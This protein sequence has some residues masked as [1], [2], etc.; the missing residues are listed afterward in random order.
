MSQT[1]KEQ[2]RSVSAV[3]LVPES[4]SDK[5]WVQLKKFKELLDNGIINQGEFDNMKQGAIMLMEHNV[6][7]MTGNA[8]QQAS[9]K[10]VIV[11]AATNRPPGK[12]Y[13]GESKSHEMVIKLVSKLVSKLILI[14]KPEQ[15]GKTYEVLCRM[16][17][18]YKKS[19]T[20][21]IVFCDNSLLQTR[22]T[23]IR[24]AQHNGLGKVCEISSDPS[25]DAKTGAELLDIFYENDAMFSTIVCCAH[26]KQLHENIDHFLVKMSIRCPQY[27]F[28]I[29]IDEASKVATSK[30]MVD[31]VRKWQELDNI[32][33]IYFID[34]TAEDDHGGFSPN[35]MKSS[36][37][38]LMQMDYPSA[39]ITSELKTSTILNLNPNL[40]RTTWVMLKEF[41]MPIL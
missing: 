29:Y 35:T 27:N 41:L 25:A 3:A 28:E 18:Q 34:A 33:N 38:L 39:K 14:G 2:Q 23:K 5:L 16:V 36:L 15:A 22:Q 10:V 7:K 4:P 8:Q 21:S 40:E 12:H 9:K 37:R 17:A 13:V 31:R 20:I 6:K 1:Q 26:S 30:K 32:G 24:A 19:N 11:P